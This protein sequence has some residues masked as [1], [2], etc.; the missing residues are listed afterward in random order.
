MTF[1]E[2]NNVLNAESAQTT[3]KSM[4]LRDSLSS[5]PNAWE[6]STPAS[7][8]H[9]GTVEW[10]IRIFKGTCEGI[11]GA[12]NQ[13]RLPSDFELMTICRQAEYIMSCRPMGQFV[14]DQDDVKA[15]KPIDLIIGYLDSSYSDL[16][17]NE[18]TN[19]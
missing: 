7:S 9:Q 17:P 16:L 10:N 3:W 15:L 2:A 14:G 6:S 13:A 11:L 5:T 1:I 19:I 18:T 4:G 8:H 12:D